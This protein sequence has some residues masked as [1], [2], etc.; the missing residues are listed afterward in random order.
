[1]AVAAAAMAV[2]AMGAEDTEEGADTT[3]D[4]ETATVVGAT[5]VAVEEAG[6]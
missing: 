4:M 6:M 5:V 1:M 2:A 3:G